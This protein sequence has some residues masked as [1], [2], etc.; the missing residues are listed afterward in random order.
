MARPS[1]NRLPTKATQRMTFGWS[2]GQHQHDQRRRQRGEQDQAEQ[3]VL[4]KSIHS[5]AS[6]LPG[7]QQHRAEDDHNRHDDQQVLLDLAGLDDAE[8]AAES[9]GPRSPTRS[10][11]PLTTGVSNLSRKSSPSASDARPIQCRVPSMRPLSIQMERQRSRSDPVGRLDEDRVVQLVDVI[12]VRAAASIH[13]R[14]ARARPGQPGPGGNCDRPA[15]PQAS[16]PSATTSDMISGSGMNGSA[17]GML[18]Q[19]AADI[20]VEPVG[21]QPAQ[22]REALGNAHPARR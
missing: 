15:S 13:R 6:Q 17:G 14:P 2:V 11:K 20:V 4:Q 3:V 5:L 18:E 9:A 1:G 22:H 19:R 7:R 16:P 21:Q 8:G 12:L 10:P